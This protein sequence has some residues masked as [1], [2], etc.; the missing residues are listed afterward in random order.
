[1]VRRR[2]INDNPAKNLFKWPL[3]VYYNKSFTSKNEYEQCQG[4]KPPHSKKRF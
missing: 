4:A 1:M 3:F 2:Q